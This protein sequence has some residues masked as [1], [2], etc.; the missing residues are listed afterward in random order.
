MGAV[1]GR[2]GRSAGGRGEEAANPRLGEGLN[3]L[4]DRIALTPKAYRTAMSRMLTPT[5]AG[6]G[7]GCWCCSTILVDEGGGRSGL[8]LLSLDNN[9]R[10]ARQHSRGLCSRYGVDNSDI[11]HWNVVPFPIAGVKN[12]GSIP[13]ERQRAARWTREVVEL[14]PNLEIVLLLGAAA[15]DGWKRAA[16]REPGLYVV[17]G[18]I[19][20]L[21][22]CAASIPVTAARYSRRRSRWSPG[23]LAHRAVD[24]C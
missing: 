8:G 12:G 21:V 23:L 18:K 19:P 22:Q 9:D 6:S 16:V 3:D 4:A 15:R 13:A 7:R 1:N 5:K 10:T 2:N 11:V 20:H 14:L 17:P 24:Q